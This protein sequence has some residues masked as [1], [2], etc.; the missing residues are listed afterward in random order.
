[1]CTDLIQSVMP[2]FDI[3]VGAYALREK[4]PSLWSEDAPVDPLVMDVICQ[5]S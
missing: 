4:R 2:T 5:L 1:M 3:V